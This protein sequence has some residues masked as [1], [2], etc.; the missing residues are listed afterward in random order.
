MEIENINERPLT[1]IELKE[2]LEKV[3]KRDSGLPPRG[4]KT[5]EYVNAYTKS[6]K[7]KTAKIKEEVKKLNISRL[8]DKQIVKLIDL[9]PKDI[10]SL[11]IIL[12]G[13]DITL[14]TEDYNKLLNTLT[15]NA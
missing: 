8:K 9:A 14:K 12:S 5:Q 4:I 3:S 13:D 1:L 7:D 6:K 11:K 15:K 2:E 10:D